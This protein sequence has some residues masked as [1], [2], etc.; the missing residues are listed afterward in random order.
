MS[1]SAV[2]VLLCACVGQQ[3]SSLINLMREDKGVSTASLKTDLFDAYVECFVQHL[4]ASGV[5]QR[6]SRRYFRAAHEQRRLPFFRV[7]R[8]SPGCTPIKFRCAACF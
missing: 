1:K 8:N 3:R 2:N 7:K 4:C 5:N 6:R